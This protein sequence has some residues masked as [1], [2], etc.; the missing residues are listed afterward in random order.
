MK[1]ASVLVMLPLL[2]V[3][4]TAFAQ[5]DKQKMIKQD[6]TATSRDSR[7]LNP[8][9]IPP[10]KTDSP[11]VLPPNP[12]RGSKCTEQ[13]LNPQ[14]IPP[15]KALNPQPIPPGHGDSSP[16]AKKKKKKFAD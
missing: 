12:C 1:V 3:S 9:P 4:G 10:G 13:A 2:L 6:N 14:P 15:G 16:R 5:S 11:R 8:Q 7:A